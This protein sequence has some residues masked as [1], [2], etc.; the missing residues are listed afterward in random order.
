[1]YRA[2]LLLIAACLATAALAEPL[3]R[4]DMSVVDGDT[5]RARGKTYRL[6]GFDAPETVNAKCDA[7]RVLGERASKRLKQI[8][9]LGAL[10]LKEVPCSCLPGTTGTRF[11][12][13]GRSCGVLRAGGNNVG[14]IL[15]REG[16]ARPFY[17]GKYH[18]PKRRNWC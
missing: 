7:E 11:C 14:L 6:V 8:A 5:I 3:S 16:L 13:H 10:D 9:D 12:N 4:S 1:M 2:L 17:C 18:C 15:I